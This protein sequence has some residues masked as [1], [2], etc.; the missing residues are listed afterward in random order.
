MIHLTTGNLLDSNCDALVNPVNTVGVMGKGL[1]LQ[2]K[3]AWPDNYAAYRRACEQ[4]AVQLGKMFV[5]E[6]GNAFA[7]RFIINFPSKGH[8]RSASRLEDIAAGLDDLRQVIDHYAITSIAIPPVG[9]GLGGL[10][11][12]V[13]LPMIE[14][15]FAHM[16]EVEAFIFQ[17]QTTF[18]GGKDAGDCRPGSLTR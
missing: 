6:T 5:F 7:P 9:C 14:K 3:Q 8:W 18:A 2:F 1:A 11:W 12:L 16:P 10:D 4:G 15:A 13:V 17:P